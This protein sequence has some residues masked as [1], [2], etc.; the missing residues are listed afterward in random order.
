MAYKQFLIGNDIAVTIYKRP[1][2]RNIR[3]SIA[4]NGEVRVSL[5]TW[6]PYR[7]GL[8]FAKSRLAWIQS[9]KPEVQL[10]KDNQAIGKAHH[11]HFTPS[12]TNRLTTRVKQNEIIISY[13]LNLDI[14]DS[15]V[16]AKAEKAAIKALKDQSES[17]LPKRLKILA[18]NHNF[19]YKSVQIKR[20]KSR[21]GSCDQDKN[22][23]LNLYLMQL[24]WSLI[25]Y[26]LLHELVHT[27]VLKHGHEFWAEIDKYNSD[28][29]RLRRELRN[30]KTIIS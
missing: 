24:P 16:Q 11:I 25:D 30:Y 9:N 23:V 8:E 21:W 19:G 15:A 29:R 1:K 27:K 28:A 12:K 26:V 20:L 18:D 13:P 6:A 2:S 4:S 5:P 7:A 17:L 22:I 14:N 10:I 3:L